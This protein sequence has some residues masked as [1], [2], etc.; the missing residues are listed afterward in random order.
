MARTGRRP[1][2]PTTI[3]LYA[4]MLVRAFG[5]AGA[6]GAWADRVDLWPEGCKSI[7]RA[8]IRWRCAQNGQDPAFWLEQLPRAYAVR[9]EVVIPS[10]TEAQAYEAA[11]LELHPERRALALLALKLGF[12]AAELCALTRAAVQR[13]VDTG[14]LLFVRKGG[15]EQTV[16]VQKVAPLLRALLDAPAKYPRRVATSRPRAWRVAGEVLSAGGPAAQYNALRLLV[17]ETG[18]RAG[19]KL[20]PHLLR[21]AFATRLARDGASVFVVQRALNHAS[22]TTTQRY[23]HPD[24]DDVARFT[25]A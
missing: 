20:R 9:R 12:R 6:P 1:L 2:S 24:A 7:L 14:D 15:R 4:R 22:V 10:E 16:R 8:A 5:R 13:A 25:R 17:V 23:V 11:A 21:H 19:L 18:R 3:E